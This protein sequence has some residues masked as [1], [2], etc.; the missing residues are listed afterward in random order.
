MKDDGRRVVG[1]LWLQAPVGFAHQFISPRLADFL[2]AHPR[3]TI[4]VIARNGLPYFVGEAL[5][6]AVFIGQLPD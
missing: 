3:L 1:H 5:D 2:D 6:A 4:D